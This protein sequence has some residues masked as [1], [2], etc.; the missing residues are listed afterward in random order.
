M[1]DPIHTVGA[2][3]GRGRATPWARRGRR[4]ADWAAGLSVKTFA[5]GMEVLYFPC[6]YS[7]YD[8]RLKKTAVATVNILN[9]GRS[10]FRHTR[11]P[12]DSLLR[13]E[14]P[15][16]RRRG[17]VQAAGQGEHQDFIESGVQ[18]ILVSSPHCYHT[19]K[20]EYSQFKVNFEVVHITQYLSELIRRREA[21]S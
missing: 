11:V 19:F 2:S 16:D 13:R 5:E 10:G 4:R 6:C 8:P 15:Q 9:C 17:A 12:K 21:R 20:N 7:S 3:L 18:K 1:P 14:H